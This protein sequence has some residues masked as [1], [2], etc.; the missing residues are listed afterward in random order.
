MG[1][2]STGTTLDTYQHPSDERK[3]HVAE[4]VA[5]VISASGT[6]PAPKTPTQIA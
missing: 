4:R 1:Y 5:A 2:S 6:Q 3:R